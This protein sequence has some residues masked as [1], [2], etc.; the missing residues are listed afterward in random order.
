MEWRS[1]P[2]PWSR[3]ARG[4]GGRRKYCCVFLPDGTASLTPA[5]SGLSVRDMLVGLCEKRGFP[6][7]DVIIYLQTKDKVSPQQPLSLDQDSAVLRDQQVTLE[8][9]VTFT[10]EV[11]FTGKAMGIMAKS[12]KTLTHTLASVLQKHQLRP[13]DAVVTMSGSKEPLNLSMSVF[14]LANKRLVL[15]RAKAKEQASSPKLTSQALPASQE[16]PAGPDGAA[17]PR[18]RRSG[19]EPHPSPRTPRSGGRATSTVGLVTR[20]SGFEASGAD[21]SHLQDAVLPRGGPAGFAPEGGPG[22]PAFLMQPRDQG[23]EGR[24]EKSRGET[25]PP[26]P[27]EAPPP[28]CADSAPATAATSE[29]RSELGK[30]AD[31]A[32]KTVPEPGTTS[33][34]PVQRT[35]PPVCSRETTV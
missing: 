3:S 16:G 24:T 2:V 14:P 8:L 19:T 4:R 11:A 6:L 17:P 30:P 13:Q 35:G 26:Q 25:P 33:T 29:D 9:R 7:S 10:L 15:D 20:T 28:A 22:D 32:E 31:G 1:S 21:R 12:S 5:R 23:G 18:R 27:A 34:G